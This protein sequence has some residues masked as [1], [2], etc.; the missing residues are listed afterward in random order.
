MYDIMEQMLSLYPEYKKLHPQPSLNSS[1]TNQLEK[2][3]TRALV[4]NALNTTEN[5]PGASCLAEIRAR[6]TKFLAH[7]IGCV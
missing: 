6:V 1:N 5:L 7:E 2:E 4:P 3:H